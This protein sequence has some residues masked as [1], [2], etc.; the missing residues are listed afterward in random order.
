MTPSLRSYIAPS[1]GPIVAADGLVA[2]FLAHGIT[3]IFLFPGGTI[4]P[5][6][7]AAKRNG[8]RLV[9]PRHEQGAGYMALAQAKL[10]GTASVVMAT[11]G[12]GATNLLTPIADAFYDSIPVVVITGQVGTGD[13]DKPAALR[14]R[15][16]QECNTLAIYSSVTKA[17]F[18]PRIPEDLAAVFDEAVR[19]ATT[20]RKGPVLIDLPMNVQRTAIAAV[21]LAPPRIDSG[22]P[23]D[24]DVNVNRAV[25]REA[26][27][28]DGANGSDIS[29]AARFAAAIF[30]AERPVLIAGAGVVSGDAVAALRE[31]LAVHPMPVSCSLAGLG[32]VPSDSPICLGFHGHTGF[33]AAGLAIQSADLVFVVGSRLDVRQTG[34]ETSRF[35]P[36]ARVI[37][38]EID[39][40][41]IAH[42]R[43]KIHDTWQMPARPALEAITAELRALAAQVLQVAPAS[44]VAQVPAR[45]AWWSMIAQ[46]K[47]THTMDTSS[48]AGTLRP[49]TVIRAVSDATRGESL[50]CVT[51][52]GSHQQWTARHFVIDLPT[53]KW[54]SSCGHGTMGFDLPTANGVAHECPGG[55]VICFVGDGSCLMNLQELAFT[56][57]LGARTLVVVLD[58][59][60]L[61][62]VSQFQQLN[63]GDDPT[64]GVHKNPDFAAIAR[65]F[66]LLA[67]TVTSEAELLTALP[68]A[69]AHPGPVLIHARVD[70]NENV[71]PMLLAGQTLDAMWP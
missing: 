31:L 52:V 13:L 2:R 27:A 36:N 61:G 42:A 24:V 15:G 53:R 57:E 16:F 54:F 44:E 14:Q 3:D 7:D 34:T 46:W 8:I 39:R 47:E 58:N 23:V 43:V 33:R 62:I 30:Q 50:A 21:S 45:A 5:V 1:A 37:R 68:Q 69:L 32:A 60:R 17:T 71:S 28:I 38:V 20:G 70:T 6:L 56:A 65:A 63:W 55:R 41:E 18:Q 59:Q 19:L 12:P 48:P 35:A 29:V 26:N 11:S 9:C 40:E 49:Q 10:R 25:T 66:G 22:A 67:F 64:C 51:G 4:A